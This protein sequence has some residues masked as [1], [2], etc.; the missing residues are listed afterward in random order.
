MAPHS[1]EN[2]FYLKIRHYH[3]IIVV[4]LYIYVDHRN[5]L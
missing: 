1:I 2:N 5:Q 3:C 4:E